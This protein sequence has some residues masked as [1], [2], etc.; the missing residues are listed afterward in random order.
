M[1]S[2]KQ[3]KVSDL[4]VAFI[5]LYI[6]IPILFSIICLIHSFA[7]ACESLRK[8]KV[9]C[10]LYIIFPRQLSM[11]K[12]VLLGLVGFYSFLPTFFPRFSLQSN[13]VFKG[14]QFL[15]QVETLSLCSIKNLI[16]TSV[17]YFYTNIE[18]L[19]QS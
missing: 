15:Y 7:L 19:V 5:F 11:F 17:P 9:S 6:S 13:W 3:I 18:K 16:H 14:L 12:H 4:I 8:R 1:L 10:A 2:T